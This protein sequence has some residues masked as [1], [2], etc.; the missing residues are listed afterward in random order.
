MSNV[1]RLKKCIPLVLSRRQLNPDREQV[2]GAWWEE[3]STTYIRSPSVAKLTRGRASSIPSL[4][5]D[6][7]GIDT[8]PCVRIGTIN[9][10]FDRH[11][12][13]LASD[14]DELRTLEPSVLTVDK[15]AK[16]IIC[17]RLVAAKQSNEPFELTSYCGIV[18]QCVRCYHCKERN[19]AAVLATNTLNAERRGDQWKLFEFIFTMPSP[20]AFNESVNYAGRAIKARKALVDACLHWNKNPQRKRAEKLF[21]YAMGVHFKPCNSSPCIWS[22]IHL[23]IVVGKDVIAS[24]PHSEGLLNYFTKAFDHAVDLKSPPVVKYQCRGRV[25]GNVLSKADRQRKHKAK[26][27]SPKEL[28]NVFAYTFRNDEDDDTVESTGERQ[29]LLAAL[30]NPLTF[31]RSR[32]SSKRLM[33]GHVGSDAVEISKVRTRCPNSF[34]PGPLGKKHVYLF[35]IDGSAPRPIKVD[36]YDKEL[37][38]LKAD[39]LTLV[40]SLRN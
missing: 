15:L 16:A 18:N 5:Q 23:A 24:A 39:A 8:G 25:G 19:R 13:R 33:N 21:D 34:P 17:G 30:G 36:D 10:S 40:K 38:A 4:S 29:E 27:V 14:L 37:A 22:H 12:A 6:D 20:N 9:A 32:Q 35:P 31:S 2:V 11:A 3:A 28:E 7:H 26:V 1:S